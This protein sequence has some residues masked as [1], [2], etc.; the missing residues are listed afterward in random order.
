MLRIQAEMSYGIEQPLYRTDH[1]H[2]AKN[3]W[4]IGTG[5]C[6]YTSLL[7][8]DN[9]EKVF[10]CVEHDADMANTARLRLASP[11]ISIHTGTFH[12]IGGP[13]LFDFLLIRL[14]TSHLPDRTSLCR[15]ASTRAAED[16]AVLVID[17]DDEHFLLHP[18]LPLF[19]E[20]LSS[21]REDVQAKGGKREIREEVQ[22]SWTSA[23]FR[24]FD[25]NRFIVNSNLPHFKESMF[26]Y[27]H[28]TAEMAVGSPLSTELSD[29]LFSW[30]LN[31]ESYVQYGLFASSFHWVNNNDKSR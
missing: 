13:G 4:D 23:G 26:V 7:A 12:D 10:T 2:K 31:P 3:V 8:R 24:H 20:A 16:A 29:E 17:A 11:R 19:T 6:A 21:L 25:T 9:P 15:W 27:M 28:L 5:N 22:D 1:W 14:V 18:A 30:V